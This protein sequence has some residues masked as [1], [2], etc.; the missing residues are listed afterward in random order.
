[1]MAGRSPTLTACRTRL[2]VSAAVTVLFIGAPALADPCTAPL[3]SRDGEVFSG[4]VL[5]VGDGDGLCIGPTSN[6]KTWTEVRLADFDA[7]EL[8]KPGGREAKARLSRLVKG[9]RVQCTAQRGRN[10]S[11][12]VYDRVIAACTLNGEP[13]GTLLGRRGG[14]P[15]GR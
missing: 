3:P 7:P 13:L 10:G 8:D 4:L 9:R 1:M 6:P 14:V 15:G 11:V 12:I 2:G 5:Y